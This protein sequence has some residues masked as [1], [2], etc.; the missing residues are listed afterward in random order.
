MRYAVF[1]IVDKELLGPPRLFLT[2][3]LAEDYAV[4]CSVENTSYTEE[5]I[6]QNLSWHDRHE[7]GEYAVYLTATRD[8]R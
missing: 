2:D 5:E 7:E 4:A 6:R 3:K 1:E 8:A